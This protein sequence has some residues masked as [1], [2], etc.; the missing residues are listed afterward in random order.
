[1]LRDWLELFSNSIIYF[2]SLLFLP[3]VINR[4]IHNSVIT[5]YISKGLYLPPTC[6]AAKHMACYLS[7]S[8]GT[9]GN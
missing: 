9:A 8:E 1:M 5:I 4:S 7:Y 2:F 3:S 6:V